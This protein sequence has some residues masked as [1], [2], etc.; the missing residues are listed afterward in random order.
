M[1]AE[2][3]SEYLSSDF[4]PFPLAGEGAEEGGDHFPLLPNPLPQGREGTFGKE[5][6]MQIESIAVSEVG[7]VRDHNEDAVFADDDLRLWLVADGMGGHAAGE[8]ASRLAVDTVAAD[9]A[10]GDGLRQAVQRAH[11]AI[12]AAAK[13]NP[14]Q[15]GMGTTMVAARWVKRCFRLVWSGDSRIYAWGAGGQSRLLTRDHSFIEDLLE[16]GVLSEE[17]AQ[18]HPQKNLIR[19][20][21]GMTG[22]TH[23]EPGESN[24]RPQSA[25][26]LMLC[27]DGVSDMLGF[28]QLNELL[29][30]DQ[31]LSDKAAA[32]TRAVENTEARDNFSFVLLE[33]PAPGF[34]GLLKRWR[35]E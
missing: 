13:K 25:G 32:L 11:L 12:R 7:H 29:V 9:T 1:V 14:D 2:N 4:P 3:G 30:R 22:I 8:V 21:L 23:L 27:S 35:R 5:K 6:L 24:Y 31:S 34:S 18:D 28:E 15:A 20:A 26:G 16:R 17:E 33:H 10:A 19:Q